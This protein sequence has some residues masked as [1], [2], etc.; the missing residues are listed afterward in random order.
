MIV[1]RA[2][3]L[4]AALIL[5]GA[6]V[7]TMLGGS[8]QAKE[9]K[10]RETASTLTSGYFD[11]YLMLAV[12]EA[13]KTLSGYY[14]DG[15]CRFVFRDALAP[16][17]LYQRRELGEA[18]TVDSWDPAHPDRHF[19]TTLYSKARDGYRSQITLEPGEGDENSPRY[20]RSRITLDRS[21]WVGESF[22]D[23]GV[24]R[25]RGARVFT[26]AHAGE[27]L[28]PAPRENRLPPPGDGVWIAKTYSRAF[29]PEGFVYLNWYDPPGTPHGGY[30]R[31][32]DLYPSPPLPQ[33]DG[34]DETAQ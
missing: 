7:G 2:V 1:A 12:N 4:M 6:L 26:I 8:S 34:G 3:K 20:C 27:K 22:I 24:V 14:N 11:D 30:V 19:T 18:Y 29:S 31:Q 25:K 32:E 9:E 5:P 23:V 28:T 21:S 10:P 33:R 13:G 17:E 16:V 15:K